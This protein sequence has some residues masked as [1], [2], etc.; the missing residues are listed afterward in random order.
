MSDYKPRMKADLEVYK[1]IEFVR[2]FSLP[3]EQK[4]I[5]WKTL[6]RDK[7]IKILRD[8]VLLNDCILYKDYELWFA[9][10]FASHAQQEQ[11]EEQVIR[12]VLSAVLK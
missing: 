8:N 2:I 1:G 4:V 3:D 9:E 6:S 7:I 10:T 12:P 5:I 11:V